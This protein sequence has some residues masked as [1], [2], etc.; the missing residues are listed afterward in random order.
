M[1]EGEVRPNEVESDR[2]KVPNAVRWSKVLSS[3][4]ECRLFGYHRGR[5]R[6]LSGE[7][8][9]KCLVQARVKKSNFYCIE[10][11]FYVIIGGN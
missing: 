1:A 2:N 8:R 10:F 7:C 6:E 4:R 5:V 11:Y 9:V 3:G